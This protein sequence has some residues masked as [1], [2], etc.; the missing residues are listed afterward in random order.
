MTQQVNL[1]QQRFR[2]RRLV[3]PLNW[4]IGIGVLL[5]LVLAL[6]SGAATLERGR[7]QQRNVEL[8][9]QRQRLAETLAGLEATVGHR[10]PN[11]L[12]E[13]K[14]LKLGQDLQSR[15]QLLAQLQNY[16]R[17]AWHGFSAH[18]EGLARRHLDG[19]WLTRVDIDNDGRNLVLGG[20]ALRADLVPAYLQRLGEEPVFQGIALQVMNLSRPQE[21]TAPVLFELRS[22]VARGER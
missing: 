1:Y 14:V 9:S 17:P 13:S 21:D 3:L 10:Q 7:L 16:A 20:K 18:L 11:R 8:E 4:I 6:V 5:V 19:T 2:P 15:R 12:L 22:Q